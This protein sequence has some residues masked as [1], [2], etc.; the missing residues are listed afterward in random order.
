MIRDRLKRW[1]HE[2]LTAIHEEQDSSQVRVYTAPWVIAGGPAPI[3]DGAVVFDV[4]GRVLACGP[5]ADVLDDFGW[6]QRAEMGG[7]LLPGLVDA[8]AQLELGGFHGVEVPGGIGLTRFI[9][10]LREVRRETED[11]DPESR[12]ARI[13]EGVRRSVGAGTAAVGDVSN[14]LR[15]VPAM[16]REGLY[17]IVFHEITGFSPRRAAKTLAAA[18]VAKARIVPWPEGIRYR[19]A[20][21]SLYSTSGSTVRDLCL[22]AIEKG[23]VT[24]IRLAEAQEEWDLLDTGVGA[25]RALVETME[26]WWDEFH[27]PGKDPVSYMDELG[28]LNEGVMLVH[29]TTATR[30]MVQKV[31]RAGA[32][33]VVCPRAEQQVAG[34]LPPL[35]SFLE[36]GC[37]VALGTAT[38][39][40]SPDQSV[41]RE[42]AELHASF[43]EVPP[44]VLVKAA[45]EGGADALGL[46]MVGSLKPGRAP[47]L[48]HAIPDGPTPDDPS[49]WLLREGWHDVSWLERCAPPAFAHSA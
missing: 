18:A 16:S 22:R 41:L 17:G 46:D 2:A 10:K 42:A 23:A 48:L 25:A 9:H 7:V 8:H 6:A 39:T 35:V 30:E 45:T 14:T 29:M 21:H 12:E 20:P 31:S 34:K 13:R 38:A 5:R 37:R 40:T 47:G 28:A 27:P 11:L 32:P 33:L 44:L 19:L 43:P 15:A 49:A 36:E 4:S 24:T 3:R 26:T 1:A